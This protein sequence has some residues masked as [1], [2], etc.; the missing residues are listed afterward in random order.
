M[1]RLRPVVL[2]L[3]WFGICIRCRSSTLD[4]GLS[5][6]CRGRTCDKAANIPLVLLGTGLAPTAPCSR[7]G[8]NKNKR[9]LQPKFSRERARCVRYLAKC[10]QALHAYENFNAA[11]LHTTQTQTPT[12]EAVGRERLKRMMSLGTPKTQTHQD[13]SPNSSSSKLP[14]CNTHSKS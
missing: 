10:C 12:S 4:V 14:C 9:W 1:L 6:G 13:A 2:L 11:P 7:R 5:A 3:G 8:G